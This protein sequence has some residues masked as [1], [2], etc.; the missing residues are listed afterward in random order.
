MVESSNT[1]KQIKN[2]TFEP[3]FNPPPNLGHLKSPLA[4]DLEPALY[5]DGRLLQHAATG[6]LL[7]SGLD[8]AHWSVPGMKYRLAHS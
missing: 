4:R 2:L 5:L 3:G 7:P 8:S 6:P 1:A